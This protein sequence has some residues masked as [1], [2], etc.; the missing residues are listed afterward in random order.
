MSEKNWN[1]QGGQSVVICPRDCPNR[2]ADPNCHNAKTCEV[3]A[4][5]EARQREIYARKKKAFEENV[6]TNAKGRA[7]ET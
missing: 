6:S 1:L 5:H 7:Y 2:C 4:A 3:W